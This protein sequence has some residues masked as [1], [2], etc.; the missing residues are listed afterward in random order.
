MEVARPTSARLEANAGRR[1]SCS[2]SSAVEMC[3][4]CLFTTA[5][6]QSECDCSSN[7][8]PGSSSAHLIWH[9]PVVAFGSSPAPGS[10]ASSRYRAAGRL[11]DGGGEGG[12]ELGGELGG[13][14]GGGGE[15]EKKGRTPQ[16]VQSV[17]Y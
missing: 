8:R 16:S 7:R 4:K 13:N 6:F 5:A 12:G 10:H 3:G 9:L 17:P 15:G 2:S 14:D 11:G 1:K